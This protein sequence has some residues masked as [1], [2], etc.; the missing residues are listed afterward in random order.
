MKNYSIFLNLKKYCLGFPGLSNKYGAQITLRMCLV[1]AAVS[2][3]F[4]SLVL[5]FSTLVFSLLFTGNSPSYFLISPS[6]PTFNFSFPLLYL[7]YLSVP[8]LSP[9]LR[10]TFL[11][12]YFSL[13]IYS[14]LSFTF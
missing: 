11:F 10:S 3:A 8:H 9:S 2:S 14:L 1:G 6:P 4:L 7:P 12:S 5:S 13:L